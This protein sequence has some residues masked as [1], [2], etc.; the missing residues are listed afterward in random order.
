MEEILL[1]EIGD[2]V[3]PDEDDEFVTKIGGIPVRT[4]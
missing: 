2:E 3:F 1:G 4:L